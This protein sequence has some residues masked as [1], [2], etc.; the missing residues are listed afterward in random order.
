MSLLTKRVFGSDF[1]K[2][3]LTLLSAALI[4]QIITFL[5]YPLITRLYSENEF[6]EFNFYSR[7]IVFLSTII[8]LRFENTLPII[9]SKNNAFHF[10]RFLIRFSIV[11][12]IIIS[13]IA[14][15][16]LSIKNPK[17]LDNSTLLI[18]TL[19]FLLLGLSNLGNNW[20]IREKLFS[21]IAYSKV[22]SAISTNGFRLMFFYWGWSTMGLLLSTLIGTF[23]SLIPFS[24]DF[25]RLR[26]VKEI[27]TE[28]NYSIAKS[29]YMFPIYN[30]PHALLELGTDLIVAASISHFYGFS[31]FGSYS[32]SY[33]LLR[34]PLNTIGQSIGQVFFQRINE[35][36]SERKKVSPLFIKTLKT[37]FLIGI[38]PFTLLLFFGAPLFSFL[39]GENWRFAGDLAAILSIQLFINFVVSSLSYV[40]I[41]FK[42]QFPL[43]LLGLFSS[44]FQLVLFYFIPKLVFLNHSVAEF[45]NILTI[46][47]IGMIVITLFALLLY[48]KFIRVHD[49][50]ILTSY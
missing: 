7:W 16:Y 13:L 38:I 37:L 42:K 47:S 18:I 24:I 19:C 15:F 29:N 34:M 46:Y 3:V 4:A 48:W 49:Q 26:K 50:T 20:S 36:V 44:L 30:L 32:L 45:E 11:F 43:F 35:N 8:T 40:G 14:F 17:T 2:S 31:I 1:K 41:T 39:F 5:F 33:L 10:Y 28:S 27:P 12:S 22:S 21:S 6:G 25:L 9:K 23:I